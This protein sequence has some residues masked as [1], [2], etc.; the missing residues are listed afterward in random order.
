MFSGMV[1]QTD[2]DYYN[3]KCYYISDISDTVD[4]TTARTSCQALGA[5]L[6]S[7]D[8]AAEKDFVLS[9]AYEFLCVSITCVDRIDGQIEL[10]VKYSQLSKFVSEIRKIQRVHETGN[11]G[12]ISYQPLKFF[13]LVLSK[14]HTVS[15][16][17]QDTKPLPTTSPNVSRFSY[18]FHCLSSK[19]ALKSRLNIS[20]YTP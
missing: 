7:L 6:V 5:D 9:I 2:W 3:D 10:M 16:K 1:C 4:H 11:N 19:F 8:D 15:Q 18:F 14:I 17:K 13:L 20:P 12:S